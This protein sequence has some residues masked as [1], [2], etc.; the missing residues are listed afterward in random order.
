MSLF[1]IIKNDLSLM[2]CR[3]QLS[4]KGFKGQLPL[5]ICPQVL[6]EFY[7][8]ITN[9]R[10]VTHPV[11]A[12]KGIAEVEKLAAT[13]SIRKIHPTEDTLARTIKLLRKYKVTQLETFD[14]HLVATMLSN[15]VTRIYTFNQND[16]LKF[17][18]IET[19]MP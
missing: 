19:M 9:P 17:T 6:I 12:A 18:E 13:K 4:K 10:R 1:T 3:K 16:F 11:S 8:T 2:L 14:L 15:G 5:C 7:S